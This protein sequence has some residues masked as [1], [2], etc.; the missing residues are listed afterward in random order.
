MSNELISSSNEIIKQGSKSFSLAARLFKKDIFESAI[1]LYRWCRFCDDEI[2]GTEKHL[3]A[4]KL[5]YLR[6]QTELAIKNMPVQH[7]AFVALRQVVKKHGIPAHYPLELINGLEMD[8]KNATYNSLEDLKL[9]CYRVAGVVG[10]MMAHIMKISNE[11]ALKS[12]CDMGMAMQMTNIARDV[13]T[14]ADMGRIYLPLNWLSEEQVPN[15]SASIKN[16]IYHRKIHRV[17]KRLLREASNLY[18]SGDIGIKYLEPKSRFAIISARY[19]YSDIGRLVTKLGPQAW[20]QRTYVPLYRKLFWVGL[21][22][23]RL[24]VQSL[25]TPRFESI[26]IKQVWRFQ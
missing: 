7:E 2:D 4:D 14:D 9:Y 3:Q 20:Y 1:L 22:L 12:A 23:F 10:L 6:E 5:N 18:A 8:V 16:P 25:S 15:F 11:G 26:H 13:V 24:L 17:T 21:S 19:I